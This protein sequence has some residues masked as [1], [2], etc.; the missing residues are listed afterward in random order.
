M[1]GIPA[2]QVERDSVLLLRVPQSLRPPGEVKGF[3]FAPPWLSICAGGTG[4]GNKKLSLEREGGASQ[5]QE[6]PG[7]DVS[8]SVSAP[9]LIWPV[10]S[11]S[12]G[13]CCPVMGEGVKEQVQ[14]PCQ[15]T[16]PRVPWR[17]QGGGVGGCGLV[18][19]KADLITV[20]YSLCV[21]TQPPPRVA[22]DTGN[23][24]DACTN[25]QDSVQCGVGVESD[26]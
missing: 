24:L 21:M 14:N 8:C 9:W 13:K 18:S 2:V 11:F 22:N 26:L 23:M 6:E 5:S 1:H 12:L 19:R 15:T 7:A 10:L 3:S 25:R 17:D 16:T 4:S 20:A